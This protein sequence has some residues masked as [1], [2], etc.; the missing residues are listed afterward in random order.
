[1]KKEDVKLGMLVSF[2]S[3]S[4]H[5]GVV[6]KLNDKTFAVSSN[7]DDRALFKY[8]NLRDGNICA[9]SP[10]RFGITL[11]PDDRNLRDEF[12]R[13]HNSLTKGVWWADVS[14]HYT[15]L[16]KNLL[17]VSLH[18]DLAQLGEKVVTFILGR[19]VPSSV[20]SFV[21]NVLKAY[22]E[23]L[24]RR[25]GDMDWEVFY[26]YLK[27]QSG[28]HTAAIFTAIEA[29]LKAGSPLGNVYLYSYGRQGK[30]FYLSE[31][32]IPSMKGYHRDTISRSK[33][34]HMVNDYVC[35]G[36]KC[37]SANLSEFG[38]PHADLS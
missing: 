3:G 17:D 37:L 22:R 8:E 31:F 2:W 7:E 11:F 20:K 24:H 18:N 15:N 19:P 21:K 23:A 30:N 14:D 33:A 35:L 9:Y 32:K 28:S 12:L 38:V 26:L 13:N 34:K 10:T 29:H 16:Y 5:G 25:E 1:M 4:F 6:T 27:K 36:Y